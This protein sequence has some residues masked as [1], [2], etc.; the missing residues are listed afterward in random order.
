[1]TR[2]TIK[3]KS[4]SNKRKS[5]TFIL[6]LF[7]NFFVFL[8]LFP[9]MYWSVV[10]LTMTTYI[11]CF[12]WVS[13]RTCVGFFIKIYFARMDGDTFCSLY[14]INIENMKTKSKLELLN[15]FGI[16]F[17]IKISTTTTNV[18]STNIAYIWSKNYYRIAS[19]PHELSYVL[20]TY[21]YGGMKGY[22][23]NECLHIKENISSSIYF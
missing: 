15:I 5:K 19:K 1:M 6:Y 12:E 23:D 18:K 16:S 10:L 21:H 13:L 8:L 20:S 9:F 2:K 17:Y 14:L 4:E 7:L 11:E 3:W 22:F